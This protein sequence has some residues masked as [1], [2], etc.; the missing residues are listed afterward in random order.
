MEKIPNKNIDDLRI[1]DSLFMMTDTILIFDHVDHKI[2]VV[3]NAHIKGDP[4]RAYS[5]AIRK[6]DGIIKNLRKRPLKMEAVR[7]KRI[8]GA[9]KVRSNFTK[10]EYEA[11]VNKAKE[12]IRSG[13]II[14]VVPSQRFEME[15]SAHPFQIYRALR[16]VNPSPYM[17]YLK[18]GGFSLVGSSPEIMVRCED[19]KVELRPIAGTRRRGKSEREDEKLIA[20]LLNDSPSMRF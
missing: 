19:G 10:K 2:K 5:E 13:D 3:S 20:D 9:L 6:I 12:Y 18:L 8:S 16:S 1:P 17:Y 15:V 11:T 14:Q 4:S 7:S